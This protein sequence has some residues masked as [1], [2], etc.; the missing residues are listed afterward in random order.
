[1]NDPPS[2]ICVFS[3]RISALRP[4]LAVSYQSLEIQPPGASPPN[5]ASAGP[6]QPAGKTVADDD[7]NNA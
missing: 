4:K 5:R 6:L 1:M 7:T 3:T 2:R